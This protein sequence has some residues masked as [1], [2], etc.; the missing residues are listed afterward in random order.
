L[1]ERGLRYERILFR[2]NNDHSDSV[3][4]KRAM[5]AQLVNEG[6]NLSDCIAAYDDR[7]P[8]VDMYCDHNLPGVLVSI[9]E[10]KRPCDV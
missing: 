7:Q 1:A 5:L 8:V 3:T 10:A 6:Y 9:D 4:V 2:P